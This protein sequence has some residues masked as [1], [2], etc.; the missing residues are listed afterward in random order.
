MDGQALVVSLVTPEHRAHQVT[1]V[2]V[3]L[4][5]GVEHQASV[6]GQALVVSLV[7][8]EYQV[9]QAQAA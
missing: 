5:V 8:Q 7:T 2:S 6:D 3:E 4:L 1:R 9:G